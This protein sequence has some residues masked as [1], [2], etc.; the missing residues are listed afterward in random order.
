MSTCDTDKLRD[1]DNFVQEPSDL[2]AIQSEVPES[3]K[4]NFSDDESL[5]DEIPS[6]IHQFYTNMED[7]VEENVDKIDK[8]DT[9]ESDGDDAIEDPEESEEHDHDGKDD[10]I[11]N[12]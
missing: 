12:N 9:E 6:Q 10:V 7:D 2:W 1:V 5:E 11:D 4:D 8:N 3:S